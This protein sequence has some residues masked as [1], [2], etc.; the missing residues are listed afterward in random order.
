MEKAILHVRETKKRGK[1]HCTVEFENGKKMPVPWVN[2]RTDYDGKECE[3]ERNNG[4]IIKI[5]VGDQVF[6]KEKHSTSPFQPHRQQPH[7]KTQQYSSPSNRKPA[8]AP[9]NFIPLPKCVV[10]APVRPGSLQLPF[11]RYHEELYSGYID[12][13][14]ETLTPLYIRRL[15]DDSA[16]F[17]IGDQPR[18]PGS[19]LRGMVR[20]LV[21]IV[22][23]SKF[24]FFDDRRLYYRAV[25]DPTSLGKAYRKRFTS[26]DFRDR[27]KGL[28]VSVC[29]GILKKEGKKYFVYPSKKI[30]GVQYYRINMSFDKENRIFSVNDIFVKEFNFKK[31]YFEPAYEK[32][33]EHGTRNRKIYLKYALVKKISEKKESNL[34]SGYLV[35]SGYIEK[36]HFQWIINDADVKKK[37][38]IPGKVVK[39]YE[40]DLQHS[41][42]LLKDTVDQRNVILK[43]KKHK[44]G[45]PVFYL[46]DYEGNIVAFGHTPFFRLPYEKT[47]GEHIPDKVKNN[48]VVDIAEAMFGRLDEWASRVFFE[49]APCVSKGTSIFYE[50][51]SPRILSSPKPTTFQHYLEQPHGVNTPKNEL[52]H[53]ND[54]A[55]IRGYK[56]YWH[57][58][59]SKN[60]DAPY[61]WS[62]GRLFTDTQHTI[63]QPVKPE[64]QFSGR[65]RFEN[66]TRE[67]LGCLLFVL[68]LPEGCAH[69]LGMGKPLGLGSVRIVPSLV[70]INRKERYSKLFEQQNWMV[71]ERKASDEEIDGFVKDFENYVLS[72]LNKEEKGNAR[73]LWDTYR[74]K[75]LKIMLNWK[76]TGLPYWNARTRY[77]EIERDPQLG[78][79]LCTPRDRR[80]GKCNEFKERYVLPKPDEIIKP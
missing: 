19:S 44:E 40:L 6:L 50:E 37:I 77:L 18:I 80:K 67:E 60:P 52:K 25:G 3:V 8:R 75:L 30:K 55:E 54:D 56:L 79:D 62:E 65:I 47:I 33:Y 29:A 4:Q 41:Q 35:C 12:L 71:G 39:E 38:E 1:T 51:V 59:T 23:F 10:E 11:D 26:G 64:T 73:S 45:V 24:N 5:V 43:L 14:I 36:K 69:K 70:L 9:Y 27:N 53:W 20:T 63:I 17:S 15:S 49:D 42:S 74:L 78:D 2:L 34:I 58:K 16:F 76:N 21:E 7:R 66:L 46:T 72:K 13:T 68:K 28:K 22:S 61:S 57:R 32:V 31:I 48:D